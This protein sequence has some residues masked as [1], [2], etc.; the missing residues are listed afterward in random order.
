VYPLDLQFE[1]FVQLL[2]IS[3]D[4][5]APAPRWRAR[6]LPRRGVETFKEPLAEMDSRYAKITQLTS[7]IDR[8]NA[9]VPAEQRLPRI[10][11]L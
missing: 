1:D 7:T 10:Y 9:K 5:H 3:E 6:H 2:W 11:L 4:R 8:Y